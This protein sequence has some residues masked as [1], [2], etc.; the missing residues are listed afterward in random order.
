ML[1]GLIIQ[2]SHTEAL[3]AALTASGLPWRKVP[4][5]SGKAISKAS[6]SLGKPKELLCLV[7]TDAEEKAALEQGFFCIGYLN[8]EL[9]GQKL[10]GCRI[11]LEGFEEID[12]EFLE[13]VH[14]RALG[15]PVTIA[16][17][18]RL[19][20]R[21]MTLAD[22]P[23]LNALCRENGYDEMGEEEAK[24]YIKYMYGLYQCGMWLVT[25]KKSGCLIGRAGFGIAD[26]LDLSEMD[27]GYLT[28]RSMR[29][30]GYAEEACRAVLAYGKEVLELPEISA[31]AEAENT[32]SCHLLEKLGFRREQ[33]FFCKEQKM[34]RYRKALAADK[35]PENT[36]LTG[37]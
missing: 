37:A 4:G 1:K 5:G 30:Q 32:A 26:Y 8:P 24:A 9:S 33:E 28:A 3:E 23:A 21:E 22:L 2:A 19:R 6:G 17:T 25:E 14:T 34:Y 27:L 12:R 13:Q 31:Y 7:E 36:D 11:L 29:R 35:N 10:S 18:A 16:E 20:I 15:L